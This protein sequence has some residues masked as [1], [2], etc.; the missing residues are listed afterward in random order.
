[1]AKTDRDQEN[2][3]TLGVFFAAGRDHAPAPDPAFLARVSAAASDAAA[4]HDTARRAARLG[5]LGAV[6]DAVGGWP[7]LGGLLT[8]G[9]AGLWLG[10]AP[11][12]GM[13]TPIEALWTGRDAISLYLAPSHGFETVM[14]EG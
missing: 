14:T 3:D 11:P 4:R 12:A 5:R 1:M 13:E 8:A 7:A 10:I 9:L 2:A 6:R